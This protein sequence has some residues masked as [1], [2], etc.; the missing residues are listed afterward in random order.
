MPSR[1]AKVYLEAKLKKKQQE[2]KEKTCF[3]CGREGHAHKGS[4]LCPE[5]NAK[6]RKSG[7]DEYETKQAKEKGKKRRL[8]AKNASPSNTVI[9]KHCGLSGHSTKASFA[10]QQYITTKAELLRTNYSDKYELYARK[11]PLVT[12]VTRLAICESQAQKQYKIHDKLY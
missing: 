9:C 11:L 5:Y 8:E 10:C 7:K 6:K 2:N 4:Y 12:Y 3:D 1:E